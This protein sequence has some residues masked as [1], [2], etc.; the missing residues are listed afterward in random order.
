MERKRH[1]EEEKALQ[2]QHKA[3]RAAEEE[4]RKRK[5]EMEMFDAYEK[6]KEKR[7]LEIKRDREEKEKRDHAQR[8]RMYK[9]KEEER[10]RAEE[11]RRRRK[12]EKMKSPREDKNVPDQSDHLDD[13]STDTS[14]PKA[15][16]GEPAPTL[17]LLRRALGEADGEDDTPVSSNKDKDQ[18]KGVESLSPNKIPPHAASDSSPP[19]P[20]HSP[21]MATPTPLP[22][23]RDLS[24]DESMI[25]PPPQDRGE[26]HSAIDQ[27]GGG[28]RNEEGK[29][30]NKAAPGGDRAKLAGVQGK[31][32]PKKKG[33]CIIL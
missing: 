33:G 31:E 17:E 23:A 7:I 19:P 27:S 20:S 22:P 28:L 18:G 13:R 6:A 5:R 12:V 30:G 1:Q 26:R 10:E 32:D 3:A 15:L 21:S 29:S 8:L 4:E 2:D 25:R 9:E 24:P 16:S 14:K 11:E